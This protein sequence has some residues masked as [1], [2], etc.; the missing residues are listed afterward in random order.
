MIRRL[1]VVAALPLVLVACS[2]GGPSSPDHSR[3]LTIYGAASLK[4]ALDR[5]KPAY[6]SAFPGTTITISTDSSA[7]LETQIEQGAPADVFLSADAANPGKLFDAG[8]TDGEPVTFAGNELTIVVPIGNPAGIA[9][10]LD[11]A[12]P[13]IKVVA[14]GDAVPITTYANQVIAN[15]ALEAG[16]P[17]DFV[18]GYTSNIVSME[19]NVKA[20]IA[21]VELGEADA[22][23]VYATDAAASDSVTTI[24]LPDLANVPA[25][26]DGVVVKGSKD[27]SAAHAFLDWLVGPDGRSILAD[28]G[29]LSPPS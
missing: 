11:L 17:T 12:R 6:A 3:E 22:G 8:L 7:A 20:V 23:I 19:D 4:G 25:R 16:D 5:L 28:L 13:G 1:G 10:P 21:K 26:Y 18:A 15:L 27:V 24:D 9:S 14:A 29:F 2:G